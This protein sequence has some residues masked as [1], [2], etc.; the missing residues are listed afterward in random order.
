MQEIITLLR[1]LGEEFRANGIDGYLTIDLMSPEQGEKF[2]SAFP[3]NRRAIE[4][5]AGTTLN[6]CE[7]MGALVQW[8][9]NGTEIHRNGYNSRIQ[10]AA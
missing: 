10:S 8:P 4:R 9:A 5:T 7:I 2:L 3:A 6:R 1:R